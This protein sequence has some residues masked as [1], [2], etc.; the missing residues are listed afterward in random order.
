M[1]GHSGRTR[2]WRVDVGALE[3]LAVP[4]RSGRGPGWCSPAAAAATLGVTV[5]AVRARLQTD[6]LR[7]VLIPG[8]TGNGRVWRG[9]VADLA[10]LR[11]RRARIE[12]DGVR[13]Y[14]GRHATIKEAAAEVRELRQLHA[15]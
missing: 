2:L 8:P 1:P 5:R 14:G 12:V 7:G 3:R 9:D 4:H 15:R 10:R 11:A 13:V 6:T